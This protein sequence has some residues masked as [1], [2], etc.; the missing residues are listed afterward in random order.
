[1]LR[2]LLLILSF[3]VL[4]LLELFP[5]LIYEIDYCQVVPYD[6][7]YTLDSNEREP[8][9]I[10][11]ATQVIAPRCIYAQQRVY[12]WQYQE[13][14]ELQYEQHNRCELVISL[15]PH[16]D[17]IWREANHIHSNCLKDLNSHEKV[18]FF[19][20]TQLNLCIV[21][22]QAPNEERDECW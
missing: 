2:Q 5:E 15:T 3:K 11:R 6:H 22:R 9:S 8:R 7:C 16:I 14:C 1:M 20:L 12:D 21:P 19:M 10:N 4:I 17:G 18:E 13:D